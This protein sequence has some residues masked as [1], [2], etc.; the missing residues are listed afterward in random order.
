M[1]NSARVCGCDGISLG[2]CVAF[3]GHFKYVWIEVFEAVSECESKRDLW[4]CDGFCSFTLV[5][6]QCVWISTLWCLFV[7]GVMLGSKEKGEPITFKVYPNQNL[8]GL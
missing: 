8:M 6:F 5:Q 4:V 3:W 1:C 7:M 2:P